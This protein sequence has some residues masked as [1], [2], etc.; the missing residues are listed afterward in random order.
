MA[1]TFDTFVN[2]NLAFLNQPVWAMALGATISFYAGLAA[3]VLPVSIMNMFDNGLMRLAF[4]SLIMW[5]ATQQPTLAVM[6]A[7]A[8]VMIINA[9]SGR[10]LLEM[11]DGHIEHS[12]SAS[13]TNE[14]EYSE[15]MLGD[16]SGMPMPMTTDADM[17]MEI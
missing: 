2:S 17:G 14:N 7:I 1:E 15:D 8:Y 5:T 12:D 9:L 3:P 13:Y 4:L 11:F 10:K 6:T 16:A